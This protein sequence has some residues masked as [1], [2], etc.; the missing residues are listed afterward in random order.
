MNYSF[1]Y[2]EYLDLVTRL[3]KKYESTVLYVR[4]ERLIERFQ[5]TQEKIFNHLNLETDGLNF[6]EF[7]KAGGLV[8]TAS[9]TSTR[10]ELQKN[11]NAKIMKFPNI[12]QL[13]RELEG[14]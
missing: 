5:E 14:L 12:Y 8:R 10:S 3:A 7:H 4:Y 1:Y 13:F 9:I 6:S 2:F 11:R